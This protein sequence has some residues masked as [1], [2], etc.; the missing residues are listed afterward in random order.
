[1]IA[2]YTQSD[3]IGL[4]GAWSKLYAY[5]P[6]YLDVRAGRYVPEHPDRMNDQR[7]ALIQGAML[8]R[9]P[10]IV[11]ALPLAQELNTYAYANLDPIK[12]FD[13]SGLQA[14]SF[15]PPKGGGSSIWSSP[16]S[17]NERCIAQSCVAGTIAGGVVGRSWVGAA[18][19]F[20][21]GF[22]LGGY[23]CPG[24]PPSLTP[25]PP[26]GKTPPS[27]PPKSN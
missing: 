18:A 1:V 4:E 10:L 15:D 21:G 27:A 17:E 24:D 6:R 5:R 8:L 25:P 22:F 12:H 20:L 26:P 14:E 19:G 11:A 16:M 7:Y 3:P 2:R 13:M 23:F 9:R